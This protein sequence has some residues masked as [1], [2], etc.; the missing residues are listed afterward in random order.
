[1]KLEQFFLKVIFTIRFN[2]FLLA[3]IQK[4][5]KLY[6]SY[7]IQVYFTLTFLRNTLRFSRFEWITEE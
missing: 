7:V 6:T 3:I 4:K 5:F 2:Q 1:M